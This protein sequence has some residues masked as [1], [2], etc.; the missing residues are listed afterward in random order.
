MPSETS[1]PHYSYKNNSLYI[2]DS[3]FSPLNR[4]KKIRINNEKRESISDYSLHFFYKAELNKRKLH[5][6]QFIF[7]RNRYL[8]FMNTN[9]TTL[10]KG[11][12]GKK[13]T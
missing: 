10:L 6:Y 8:I 2:L 12:I 5:F 9:F 3:T 7:Y 13:I 11:E 4:K 1:L